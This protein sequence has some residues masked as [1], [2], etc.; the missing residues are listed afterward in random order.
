MKTMILAA[1]L[2]TRLMP[3]TQHT[4]KPL[5]TLSSQPILDLVINRLQNAGCEAVIINTHH[6]HHKI[7]DFISS[8]GYNIPVHLKHEP[9]ILGTGGAIINAADFFDAK[10]FMLI[11][12]DIA[13]D[14]D[15]RKVYDFHVSHNHQ[16]TMVLH[17]YPEFNNVSVDSNDCIIEFHSDTANNRLAFTGIHVIDPQIL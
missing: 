2:G 16:V 4:P 14:I 15:L 5:F 10:P 1:G 8:K 13:T 12:S 11:N 6:L 9:T 7:E 3:Y 17:D